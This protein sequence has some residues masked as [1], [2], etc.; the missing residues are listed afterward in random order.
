MARKPKQEPKEIVLP[1]I[2]PVFKY[3]RT[4]DGTGWLGF[5]PNVSKE[6][7]ERDYVGLTDEEWQAHLASLHPTPTAEQLAIKEKKQRIAQLKGFLRETDWVVVKI[8][9]EVDE[10][11]QSALREKYASVIQ[12]R[13]SARGE[14]NELEGSL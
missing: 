1:P 3:Y 12:E 5:R 4:K 13:K 14:I 9:E 7:L 6:V 2:E 11:E 10:E 8:A